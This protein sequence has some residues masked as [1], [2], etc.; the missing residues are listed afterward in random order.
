[1]IIRHA[2]N[3]VK[4]VGYGKAIRF[5]IWEQNRRPTRMDAGLFLLYTRCPL[6]LQTRHPRLVTGNQGRILFL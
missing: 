2:D 1:M 5:R 3:V 6:F 4:R